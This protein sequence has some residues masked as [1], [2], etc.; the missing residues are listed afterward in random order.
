MTAEATVSTNTDS[1]PIV[2]S[3]VDTGVGAPESGVAPGST[4]TEASPTVVDP[5]VSAAPVEEAAAPAPATLLGDEAVQAPAEDPGQGQASDTAEPDAALPTTAPITYAEFVLP[6]GVTVQDPDLMG[7]FTEAL[8][9][10]NAPQELGQDLINMHL[11]QVQKA[12]ESAITQYREQAETAQREDFTRKINDGLEQSKQ[13]FGN[14]FD[15]T[16]QTAVSVLDNYGGEYGKEF[17]DV[18]NKAGLGTNP[19]VV[20]LLYKL[21]V[22]LGEGSAV[23]AQKPV[24]QQVPGRAARRYN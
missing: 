1:T 5:N 3:S 18:M 2:E 9:K 16:V 10:H 24:P 13:K 14:R 21:G 11:E 23:P 12:A 19:A 7:K 4:A 15:A 17:R 20:G 6:E 22:A 8:G